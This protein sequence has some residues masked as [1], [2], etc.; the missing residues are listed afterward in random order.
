MVVHSVKMPVSFGG[1]GGA[2]VKTKGREHAVMAHL[3]HLI[4]VKAEVNYCHSEIK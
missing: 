2:A 1:G 3:K 4:E